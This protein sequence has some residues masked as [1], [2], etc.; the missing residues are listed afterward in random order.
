MHNCNKLIL[1]H[2][3]LQPGSIIKVG[4]A[5]IETNQESII[6]TFFLNKLPCRFC[7]FRLPSK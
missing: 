6:E 4:K 1:S 2:P 5:E 7:D 3:P